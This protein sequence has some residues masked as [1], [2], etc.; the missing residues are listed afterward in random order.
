MKFRRGDIVA[1]ALP[2][3]FGG[4]PRPALVVQSDLVNPTHATVAVCPITT[5]LQDAEHFRIPVRPGARSGLRADSQ[6]MVDKLTAVRV[7]RVGERLGSLDEQEI[8]AVDQALLL[9]LGL[10]RE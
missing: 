10:G 8:E 4:R 7:S 6:V 1:C 5:H 9:W 2:G 3:D